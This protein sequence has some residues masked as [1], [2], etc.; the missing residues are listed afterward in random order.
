MSVFFLHQVRFDLFFVP[1]MTMMSFAE[2]SGCE[3]KEKVLLLGDNDDAL[4]TIL[5]LMT[6]MQMH[7]DRKKEGRNDQSTEDVAA[8]LMALAATKR[9]E[10]NQMSLFRFR[11][12]EK[13][14]GE[15]TRRKKSLKVTEKMMQET[16]LESDGGH[17]LRSSPFLF[18]IMEI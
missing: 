7:S 14:G 10:E 8:F 16:D 5:E 1:G 11:E 17:L 9:G 18:V 13:N 12:N 2:V 6:M 15:R 4:E 3:K